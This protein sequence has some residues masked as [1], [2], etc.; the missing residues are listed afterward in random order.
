ML[1]CLAGFSGWSTGAGVATVGSGEGPATFDWPPVQAASNPDSN[2]VN[3]RAHASI[4]TSDGR[5]P[6]MPPPDA[7]ARTSHRPR[8]PAPVS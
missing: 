5:T 3:N 1:G 8:G 2:P 4:A 7:T 6:R